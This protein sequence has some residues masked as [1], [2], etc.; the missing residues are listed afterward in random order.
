MNDREQLKQCLFNQSPDFELAF[1]ILVEMRD[2]G[3]SSKDA[4]QTLES[5]RKEA[6][7]ISE[8]FEDNVKDAMDW[9]SG[10]CSPHMR[11]W[12]DSVE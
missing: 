6:E 8:Q 10:W 7:P 5:L 11:I 2:A 12:P 4:Y 1:K 9:A 3:L